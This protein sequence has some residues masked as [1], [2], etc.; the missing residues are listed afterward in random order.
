MTVNQVTS[1]PSLN[2]LTVTMDNS[3]TK[4]FNVSGAQVEFFEDFT[5]VANGAYTAPVYLTDTTTTASSGLVTMDVPTHGLSIGDL[6]TI[7]DGQSPFDLFANQ[8]ARVNSATTNQFTFNLGVED[9][10]LGQSL[11]LT[12]SRQLA[13]GKGFIHQPAAPFGEFHQRRLWVPYQ[14]TSDTHHKTE[15]SAMRLPFRTFLTV[16]HSI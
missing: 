11:S 6:V 13:I 9:V 16:T 15:K 8:S 14:Y 1:V 3:Q 12:V 2:Q 10:S 4:V 5:R 7:R